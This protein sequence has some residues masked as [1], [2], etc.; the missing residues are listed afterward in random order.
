MRSTIFLKHMVSLKQSC[1]AVIGDKI[2]NNPL[3]VDENMP[4]DI[5]NFPGSS[6][7]D[8]SQI[9]ASS[10]PN[11]FIVLSPVSPNDLSELTESSTGRL[12]L[13]EGTKRAQRGQYE[14]SKYSYEVAAAHGELS[15][16]HNLATMYLH[17][18]G[19]PRDFETA[20]RFFIKCA[21]EGIAISMSQLGYM[22][23]HGR[24]VDQDYRKAREWFLR[25]ADTEEEPYA[26][27]C[28]CIIYMNGY[29][30]EINKKRALSWL[31]KSANNKF[32]P[33]LYNIGVFNETGEYGFT[34][35]LANAAIFYE[36]AI[37]NDSDLYSMNNLGAILC[38]LR[39]NFP[40]AIKLFQESEMGGI[41]Q[42]MFNLG[43]AYINGIGVSK[44]VIKAAKLYYKATKFATN[45]SAEYAL[46][47][48]FYNGIN[49]KLK[50][51]EHAAK[52]WLEKAYSHGHMSA[53]RSLLILKGR[54]R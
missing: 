14:M 16:I 15:A 19:T 20:K 33:A 30:V 13:Q 54:A 37:R 7:T 22:Y 48:I 17:G 12:A 18:Q 49:G 44:D 1:G 23:L 36:M 46:A 40:R 45:S 53:R 6:L 8:P 9:R 51:N 47:V 25:A 10:K 50:P 21:S 32:S 26:Q 34:P 24:G 35:S 31:F 28:L 43:E 29:G 4:E 2:C 27:F 39:K 41:S 38:K 5:R 3:K 42:A 52:Y 11:D